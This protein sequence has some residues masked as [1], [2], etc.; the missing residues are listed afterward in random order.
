[1]TSMERSNILQVGLPVYLS[2]ML[3]WSRKQ[4]LVARTSE[5]EL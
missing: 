5:F 4:C 1:L 3:I 2:S